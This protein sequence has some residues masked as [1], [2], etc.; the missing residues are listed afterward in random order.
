MVGEFRLFP[1]SA[2]SVSGQVDTLYIFM[3][4]VASF[5]TLL[6]FLLIVCFC[7]YYRRGAVRN[8]EISKGG[9]WVLEVTWFLIPLGL[10][11]IMFAWGADLY[12]LIAT[13]PEDC[14]TIDV[15]GKQWMWKVQ[16]ANGRREI[17]TL[18]LPVDTKVRM[19]MISEDVIHSFY[20][21]NFRVK[22]DV[23]PGRYASLWFEATKLGTYHL[24]CAEYC[25]TSH[26]GMRGHVEVMSQAEYAAWLRGVQGPTPQATGEMLFQ[27]Y[28]CHTCHMSETPRGPSLVGLAGSTVPLSDGTTVVADDDYLRESILNPS[29]KLVAGFEPLMPTYQ[30]QIG[31]EDIRALIEYIKTLQPTAGPPPQSGETQQGPPA[32]QSQPEAAEQPPG[33]QTVPQQTNSQQQQPENQE[34]QAPVG[35]NP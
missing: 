18:H 10:T 7:I 29:A 6:I 22:Q 2:S 19:R 35:E 33:E 24:F 15:M 3:L 4:C 23:L 32:N 11:M 12:R 13:P 30:G 5:F 1:E 8:R 25:G 14:I 34:D 26:S 17:N 16:H 9:F 20:I 31:E 21:P 27:Q 28:R